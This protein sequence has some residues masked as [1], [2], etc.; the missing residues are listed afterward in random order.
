M[1]SRHEKDFRNEPTIDSFNVAVSIPFGGEAV[2]ARAIA[3]AN[4]QLTEALAARQTLLR[5]LE[6]GVHEAEHNIEVDRVELSLPEEQER[7][8]KQHLMMSRIGFEV[9]EI[10]LI[11]LLKI[12][13]RTEQAI[14]NAQQH[15]IRL[16][17]DIA[18]YNQAVGE[19][20]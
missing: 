13:S 18:L 9:G 7:L 16:Q 4:V 8:S 14:R 2:A 6:Q 3:Q 17:R 12:Q 10:Q 19:M 5:Q 1:C 11:D 20:P 15:A